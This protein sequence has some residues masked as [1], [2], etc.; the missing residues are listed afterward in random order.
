MGEIVLAQRDQHAI[1]GAG[2]VEVLRAGLVLLQPLLERGWRAVLDEVG[3][4]LQELP[5]AQAPGV[6][7]LRQREDLLELVEDQQRQQR[8]SLSITQ[9]VAAVMQEF[10]QRLALDSGTGLRPVPGRG[11]GPED[12]LLDLLGGWR[13]VRRVVNPDVDGAEALATEPWYEP[14]P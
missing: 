11:R 2:E 1:V 5:G 8:P 14:G 3:E 12:S 7:S 9:Q 13:G 10:P 6:V 4:I